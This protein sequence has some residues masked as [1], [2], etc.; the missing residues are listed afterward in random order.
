MC[1]RFRGIATA[2]MTLRSTQRDNTTAVNPTKQDDLSGWSCRLELG[3]A[4]GVYA[5]GDWLGLQSDLAEAVSQ[6]AAAVV[7]CIRLFPFNTISKTAQSKKLQTYPLASSGYFTADQISTQ[8]RTPNLYLRNV[9]GIRDR[10]DVGSI[11][12]KWLC[13]KWTIHVSFSLSSAP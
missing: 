1:S 12:L 7:A 5:A 6:I 8:L 13:T 4:C 3:H 2:T 9:E 11:A 10:P